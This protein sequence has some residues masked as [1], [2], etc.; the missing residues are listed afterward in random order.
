MKISDCFRNVDTEHRAYWLGFIA[1]DG[2]I[3][4]DRNTLSIKLS[5]KD[6]RHLE[7][8]KKFCQSK[9]KL[10]EHSY[11]NIK[12]VQF[13][14][15]SKKLI[16]NLK[17]DGI[18]NK[19][20]Y[21]ISW[22]EVIYFIDNDLKKDFIRGYFDGDGCWYLGDH[23]SVYFDITSSSRSLLSGL[24]DFLN[25]KLDISMNLY[26]NRT[27]HKL[28]TGDKKYCIKI[29]NYFYTNSTIYLERKKNKAKY[30]FSLRNII[31]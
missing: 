23:K 1:S 28:R 2:Y 20:T 24:C 10:E 21:T 30:L 18:Y 14:I 5:Y 19:K 22:D 4:K 15:S 17:F 29:Y 9:N 31:L 12:Y 8:F 11:K 6:E 13:R 26:L 7:K 27:P 3:C 16:E 25:N